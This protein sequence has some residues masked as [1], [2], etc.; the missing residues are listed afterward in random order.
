MTHT[1]LRLVHHHLYRL[2]MPSP[3]PSPLPTLTPPPPL[4]CGHQQIVSRSA[5]AA[6]LLKG[7]WIIQNV[8]LLCVIVKVACN[9]VGCCSKYS[10]SPS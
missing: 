2:P 8:L 4:R 10:R 7:I 1:D 9:E 3:S 5:E 6:G